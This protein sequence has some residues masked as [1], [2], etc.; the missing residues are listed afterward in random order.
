MCLLAVFVAWILLA[1][2]SFGGAELHTDERLLINLIDPQTECADNSP[3]MLDRILILLL[4]TRIESNDEVLDQ[5]LKPP[6]LKIVVDIH[7]KPIRTAIIT[8]AS[9]IHEHLV[10]LPHNH[11]FMVRMLVSR[12]KY[13]TNLALGVEASAVPVVKVFVF[14][15]VFP[16]CAVLDFIVEVGTMH[17]DVFMI[18]DGL[19]LELLVR[20]FGVMVKHASRSFGKSGSS[21]LSDSSVRWAFS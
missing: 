9:V 21:S 7:P 3:S 16:K 1:I 18:W 4:E 14:F 10:P 11:P 17:A 8:P 2:C 19:G 5:L 12:L 20:V 6:P 13:H 15:G